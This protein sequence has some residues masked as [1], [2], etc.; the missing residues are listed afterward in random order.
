MPYYVLIIKFIDTYGWRLL[1][2]SQPPVS[3][4]TVEFSETDGLV[5]YT[6]TKSVEVDAI[7]FDQI[8]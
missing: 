3:L 2:Q 7:V 6:T 1:C 8:L 5:P 4:T